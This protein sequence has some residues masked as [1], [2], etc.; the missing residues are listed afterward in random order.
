LIG[1][2][3]VVGR[4]PEIEREWRSAGADPAHGGGAGRKRG[5]SNARR[6]AERAE[7]E[8]QGLDLEEEKERFVRDILPRLRDLSMMEIVKAT[9]FSPRYASLVK[10]GFYVPHPVHNEAL[11]HLVDCR[12]QHRT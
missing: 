4:G 3:T 10:R 1:V 12:I 9:G 11:A 5:M 6:A 8:K 7:W 2:Q